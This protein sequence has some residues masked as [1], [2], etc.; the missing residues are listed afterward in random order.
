MSL[1]IPLTFGASILFMIIDQFSGGETDLIVP[2]VCLIV[3]AVLTWTLSSRSY[4]ATA[5][6]LVGGLIGADI[7]MMTTGSMS[8]AVF[9]L[10]FPA[11][12]AALYVNLN[13]GLGVATLCTLVIWVSPGTYPTP[14]PTMR[15]LAAVQIWGVVGLMALAARPLDGGCGMVLDKP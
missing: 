8:E 5:W 9:L 10:A 2:A 12:L 13:A 4:L 6:L 15:S 7:L 14:D 3:L 11:A 1:V